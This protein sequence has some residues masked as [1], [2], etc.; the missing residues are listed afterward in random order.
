[1]TGYLIAPHD[2]CLRQRTTFPMQRSNSAPRDRALF[3]QPLDR[4]A[5]ALI[6]VLAL[7]IGLLLSG[8]ER[9]APRVREFN[10]QDKQIGAEDTAFVLTFSRP[11]DHSSVETNLRLTPPLPGKFSWAGRRMAYTLNTPAPYGTL[12]QLQLQGAKNR[13]DGAGIGRA[14][15]QAFTGRFQ[16]RDRVFAYIG[17]QGEEDGRLILYNLTQ[18]QKK[19]LTPKNLVVMEFK[20]YPLGDRLLFTATQRAAQPQGLLEQKLYRVTTGIQVQTPPQLDTQAEESNQMTHAEPAGNTELVL[21]SNTYQNLKF[22]LSSN[23]KIIIVQRVNRTDPSDFGPWILRQA[24]QPQPLKGEPGGDFLITP[25]SDSLA[26]SQGQGLAILP[27]KPDAKPLNFLPKFGMVLNFSRDGS[28]AAM[29]KFN[30]DRTR[31]RKSVV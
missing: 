13:F 8:G 31:D 26:I 22:D 14:S 7:L 9:T 12:F 3:P 28:L 30:S 2:Y 23:G 27:L 19:I 4:V 21:D 24:E 5:I 11:M 15:I 20:P 25:D 29:V 1:M 6:V 16:T 10:W 17:V 18:Q